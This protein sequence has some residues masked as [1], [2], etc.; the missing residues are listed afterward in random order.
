MGV[1]MGTS[2]ESGVLYRLYKE[3]LERHK[4]YLFTEHLHVSSSNDSQRE[5]IDITFGSSDDADGKNIPVLSIHRRKGSRKAS[6]PSNPWQIKEYSNQAISPLLV[7]QWTETLNQ[8]SEALSER[9][10]F[11]HI[12]EEVYHAGV[13]MKI[14]AKE[15]PTLT[16]KREI[17]TNKLAA[18]ITA[19]NGRH[20]GNEDT[21]VMVIHPQQ[22][23]PHLQV[24]TQII[25]YRDNGM[26][27]NIY[28]NR[29]VEN[30][31]KNLVSSDR[32]PMS[33]LAKKLAD[34]NKTNLAA[35][36]HI[37]G[38]LGEKLV[39]SS[40]NPPQTD[41]VKGIRY[42]FSKPAKDFRF[43]V[44]HV[45]LEKGEESFGLGLNADGSIQTVFPDPSKSP[46]IVHNFTAAEKL[47][48]KLK[49]QDNTRA[50]VLNSVERASFSVLVR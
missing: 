48:S 32:F 1:V 5:K 47:S 30:D 3:E 17:T 9:T 19:S 35:T 14:S 21:I 45:L 43:G 46:T 41:L 40:M 36:Q 16:N 2:R 37:A 44:L 28:S 50:S 7:Q 42:T 34:V 29:T 24:N 31:R 12:L 38:L 10:S 6:S 39:S 18:Y 49:T 20:I 8:L 22:P 27:M 25:L 33:Q 15:I 23:N 11:Y 26:A 13:W 4:N